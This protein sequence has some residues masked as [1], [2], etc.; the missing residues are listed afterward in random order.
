[1]FPLD[2]PDPPSVRRVPKG[3]PVKSED[4][5]LG[6]EGHRMHPV[7]DMLWQVGEDEER[8]H[9]TGGLRA[10]TLSNPALSLLRLVLGL[11]QA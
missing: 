9:A 2:Q 6:E 4:G 11:L 10:Q 5:P 1:M 3:Y 7:L 8:P